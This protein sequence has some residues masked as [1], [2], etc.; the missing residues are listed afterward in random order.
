ML[1]I[2][3]GNR[4]IPVV[5]IEHADDAV[6]LAQAIA[7]GG[8]GVLEV[9]LRTEAAFES[10]RRIRASLPDLVVGAGT[11]QTP[12]QA[13]Q[14][15][16]A[17]AQFGMAPG[18][19]RRIVS[20][21]RER[22]IPFVPGILTPT[23]IENA[24]ALGCRLLKFFPAQAAG[25]IA[26]LKALA[27]PF[28]NLDLHICATGGIHPSNL[29]QYLETPLVWAVGGSWIATRQQITG[30]QWSAITTRA[31]QTVDQLPDT[32]RHEQS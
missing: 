7:A 4:V 21:F 16:G 15:I 22:S 19:N 12:E 9:A 17:G 27:G 20:D 25:G 8:I 14:A 24:L 3:T 1:E 32:G 23:E 28:G 31:Q 30:K 29:R 5:E 13:R 2:L 6:P 26:Y 11:V 18:L 10:I